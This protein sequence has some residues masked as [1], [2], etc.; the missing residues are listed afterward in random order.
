MQS[1]TVCNCLLHFR[2]FDCVCRR[3]PRASRTL[4]FKKSQTD[5]AFLIL[6]QNENKNKTR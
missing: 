4:F 5:T 2:L 3:L 6:R 1:G